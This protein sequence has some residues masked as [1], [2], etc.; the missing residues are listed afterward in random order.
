MTNAAG[1]II[2]LALFGS[3]VF[4]PQYLQIVKGEGAT[5]SGLLLVPMMVGLLIT[6]IVSGQL[7]SRTGRYKI[8]PIARHGDHRASASSSSP[9]WAR[10]PR[11]S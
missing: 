1:F 5:N 7:I 3:I 8:W 11:R 6:S 9:P 2:G 4:L 10:P